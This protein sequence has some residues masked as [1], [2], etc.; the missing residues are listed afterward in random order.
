MSKKYKEKKEVQEI[1]EEDES[2]LSKKEIYDRNKL[3]REEAKAKEKNKKKNSN[4]SKKKNKK[5]SQTSLIGRIFA[6]VMLL[7]MIGSVIASF[8]SYLR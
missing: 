2:T 5:T 7:L 1:I 8:A 4:K 6:I 3:A